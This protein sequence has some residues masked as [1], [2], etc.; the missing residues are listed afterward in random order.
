MESH[1]SN[2][3]SLSRW[4]G[5]AQNQLCILEKADKGHIIKLEPQDLEKNGSHS[6]YSFSRT[7]RNLILDI[8]GAPVC[9][10]PDLLEI[11]PMPY[12]H[13]RIKIYKQLTQPSRYFYEP[14]LLLDP[15]MMQ[16]MFDRATA[17]A[18]VR[19]TIQMW[20]PQVEK[21]VLDWIKRQPGG[22]D[23]RD[24]ALQIMPYE[25]VRL[26]LKEDGTN[27]ARL[28]RL[29]SS[30]SIAYSQLLDQTLNFHLL[31]ETKEAADLVLESFRTDPAF[32][33]ENLA[34]ECV[35]TRVAPQPSPSPQRK[36]TRFEEGDLC[37]NNMIRLSSQLRINIDKSAKGTFWFK[38][39]EIL[40][41]AFYYFLLRCGTSSYPGKITGIA[42]SKAVG[43]FVFSILFY[44]LLK[45]FFHLLF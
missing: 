33:V 34:L 14:F 8:V 25:E 23:V 32:A 26:V 7:S 6:G 1:K 10:D 40:L 13:F 28:Y 42:Y 5:S 45:Q 11:F 9:H 15:K 17:R 30:G 12:Q 2:S 37:N 22:Q 24:Y 18:Y 41:I 16:S 38:M 20:N 4:S 36:R 29:P 3:S 19:L 43:Y 35:F 21:L 27:S 31:C 44:R 39:L